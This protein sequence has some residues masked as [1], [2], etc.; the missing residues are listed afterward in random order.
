[1]KRRILFVSNLLIEFSNYEPLGILY[2]SASL[3]KYGHATCFANSRLAEVQKAVMEFKP[4]I[5]AYSITT[6][7]HKEL[8]DLNRRLKKNSSFFALFGG[9]HT[10]FFPETI[11]EEGVD[12]VCIG[13]GEEAVADLANHMEKD[14]DISN[15]ENLWI[16]QGGEIFRNPVRKLIQDLDSIPFPDRQLIYDRFRD[17]RDNKIKFF[18]SNRGC[19]FKCTYCFNHYFDAIYKGKGKIVR[20]R[21]VDNVIK[22]IVQ[23]KQKYALGFL[24]FVN[25]IF[26]FKNEWI[27]EFAEKYPGKI[28]LPFYAIVRAN[29]ITPERVRYMKRAGCH[30]VAMGLESGNERIRSEV[31][32]IRMSNDQIIEACKMLKSGGIRVFT[33]NMIGLPTESLDNAFETLELNKKCRP[34]YAWVSL[35]SPYP[36]TVLGEKAKDMGLFDGNVNSFSFTYHLGSPMN[37]PDK[38]E[39]ENLQKLFA[40]AVEFPWIAGSVKYLIKLPL[41]NFYELARKIWKG[42]AFKS[43]IFPVK[44]NFGEFVKLSVKFLLTKGG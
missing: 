33:Q 16:K 37:I 40:L 27:R 13:E 43:R 42:Y 32:K 39:F 1:M 19:P 22:E 38:K 29:M 9:P 11:K 6:G 35:Y 23:V 8:L 25:D 14:E 2:L 10:T 18:I 15:I 31:L 44:L 5:I 30:S 4:H 41:M 21:S 28:G 36:N 24:K 20:I 17:S 34:D 7:M 26:F 3:K 12:G